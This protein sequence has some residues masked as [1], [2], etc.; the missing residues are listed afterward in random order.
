MVRACAETSARDNEIKEIGSH[1]ILHLVGTFEILFSMN[2]YEYLQKVLTE[3]GWWD[4]S[5][6]ALLFA[7]IIVGLGFLLKTR[8]AAAVKREL[9]LNLEEVKQQNAINLA[10]MKLEFDRRL[11]DYEDE[12]NIRSEAA[13]IVKLLAYCHA[14]GKNID[15]QEFNE[16]AWEL[17]LYLPYEMVCRMAKVLVNG[18]GTILDL[19]IDVRKYLL[20]SPH[21]KL[22]AKNILA[23]QNRQFA[24]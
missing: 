19:L 22:E 6:A 7:V 1:A 4:T 8:I 13:K 5:L 23:S 2:P 17:S 20:D 10:A 21:D 15:G 18:N 12:L 9:D 24:A 16:M 3:I 14:N 11:K